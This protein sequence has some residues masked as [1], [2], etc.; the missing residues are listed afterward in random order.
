MD[1]MTATTQTFQTLDG[2]SGSIEE[3]DQSVELKISWEE[4]SRWEWLADEKDAEIIAER[5]VT[6]II[7]DTLLRI[8]ELAPEVLQASAEEL[9]DQEF[10]L[11]QMYEYIQSLR[12][13]PTGKEGD[14]AEEDVALD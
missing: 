6:A 5:I 12:A 11:R 3:S 9:D 7:E 1:P 2:L 4:G 14:T 10:E 8:Q 13:L